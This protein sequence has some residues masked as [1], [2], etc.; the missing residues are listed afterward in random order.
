MKYYSKEQIKQANLINLE[1]F[2]RMQGE[3]LMKSG[4]DKRWAR[5]KTVTIREN[6]WHDWKT[7]EG[8]YPIEF[9]KRYFNKGFKEAMEILLSSVGDVQM[10]ESSRHNQDKPKR[11]VA[12]YR[13]NNNKRAYAYL[14]ETRLIDK[15]ILNYFFKNG[16]IYE[17]NQYHNVVFVGFDEDGIIRHAHKRSTSV[18]GK[19]FRGNVESS[20]S[21]YPFQYRGT[22]ERVYVFEA[23]IDLLSYLTLHKD[24]WEQDNYIAL[25]GLGTEGLEHLLNQRKD[26]Q[27]IMLCFDHDEAGIEACERV[28]DKLI[29][30][31][32]G[33]IGIIQ[34][35]YKDFN[36]DI[37]ALAGREYKFSKE[38]QK[39][40][41]INHINDN[42]TKRI[43]EINKDIDFNTLN[44]TFAVIFYN[45]RQANT[46]LEMI[47]EQLY[48]LTSDAL[49]LRQNL[50]N[51]EIVNEYRSMK[52]IQGD[53]I[54]GYR[55]YKDIKQIRKRIEN[56]MECM[57]EVNVAYEEYQAGNVSYERL[58][59][60]YRVL[61]TEGLTHLNYVH[62]VEEKRK[63]ELKQEEKMDKKIEKKYGIADG[64][65][66]SAKL[67]G[68]DGNIFNLMGIASRSLKKAGFQKKS[69]EMINRIT[70]S[71]KS[72]DEALNIISEYVEPVDDIGYE[73]DIMM[74]GYE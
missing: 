16:Y 58:S 39:R 4:K 31:G 9:V 48:V 15:D 69:D 42:F 38:S 18:G 55:C 32:Y 19:S 63:Q 56:L 53:M 47:K 14:S 41:W 8:G 46:K 26:I 27:S 74:R 66:P 12:P 35:T 28:T 17:D 65:K 30:K 59:E 1:D 61:A 2:L 52:E 67:I 68:E 7:S 60:G 3:T 25:N 45:R 20:D 22:S 36:E 49:I 62:R 23:P 43:H 21:R 57:K 51:E 11:F 34:S 13:N 6:M 72:Y 29:E 70:T 33:Q 71:A 54:E 10:V 37:M 40:Q 44:K 64:Q 24:N 73:E 50:I 5:M